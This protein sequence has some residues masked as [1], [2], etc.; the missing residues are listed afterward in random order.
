MPKTYYTHREKKI[1]PCKMSPLSDGAIISIVHIYGYLPFFICSIESKAPSCS[2]TKVSKLRM[3]LPTGYFSF[4]STKV[5]ES[6]YNRDIW[7]VSS[8]G[9]EKKNIYSVMH[10]LFAAKELITVK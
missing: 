10:D 4:L 3:I 2:L 1:L 7:M 9:P 8:K 5:F 6:G